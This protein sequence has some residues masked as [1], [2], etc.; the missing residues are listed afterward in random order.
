VA[1]LK[2]GSALLIL[3]YYIFTIIGNRHWYWHLSDKETNVGRLRKG[4][5]APPLA[6]NY[7]TGIGAPALID[8]EAFNLSCPA[9][10]C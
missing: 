9:S 6:G 5:G 10:V 8:T 4:L 1:V 7:D 3:T 2:K